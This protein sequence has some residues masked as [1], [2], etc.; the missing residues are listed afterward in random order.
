LDA[1]V[2]RQGSGKSYRTAHELTCVPA[3]CA[4]TQDCSEGETGRSC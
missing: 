4:M 3:L 1:A 2:G